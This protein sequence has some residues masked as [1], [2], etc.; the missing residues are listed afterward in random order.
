VHHRVAANETAEKINTPAPPP[1]R[2]S[3]EVIKGTKKENVD[4]P[5]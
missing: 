3:V 1:P 5:N 2:P 4:F